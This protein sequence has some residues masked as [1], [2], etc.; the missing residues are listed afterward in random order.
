MEIRDVIPVSAQPFGRI[1]DTSDG[2]SYQRIVQSG[3]WFHRMN[4]GKIMSPAIYFGSIDPKRNKALTSK[5]ERVDY[6]GQ[7]G[8]FHQMKSGRVFGFTP[9]FVVGNQPIGLYGISFDRVK[10][11]AEEKI[12]LI[13]SMQYVNGLHV[14]HS[15]VEVYDN[16]DMSYKRPNIV[17]RFISKIFMTPRPKQFVKGL[18]NV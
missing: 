8:I 4:G 11:I 3:L 17:E 14:G 1:F 7:E 10:E 9:R 5:T 2:S 13:D 15:I 16:L 6:N 12:D 18:I